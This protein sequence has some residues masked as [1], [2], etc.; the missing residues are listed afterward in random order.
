MLGITV[1]LLLIS[2]LVSGSEVAFFSL[3][4]STQQQMRTSGDAR[5]EQILSLRA[6]VDEPLATIL[7]TNNLVNI[8][9][10]S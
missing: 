6:N 9:I 7:V 2:A 1:I 5:D 3:S 8:C 4:P 10:V